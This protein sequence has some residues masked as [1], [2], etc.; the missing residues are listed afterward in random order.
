MTAVSI[1]TFPFARRH[2][3]LRFTFNLREDMLV[4]P[5]IGARFEVAPG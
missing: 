4:G 1:E 3:R 2:G 5:K